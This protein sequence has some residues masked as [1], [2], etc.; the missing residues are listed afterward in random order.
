MA[1]FSKPTTLP[2]WA[3]STANIFE[4]PAAKKSLGWLFQEIPPSNFENW[5][6]N[7][8]FTWLQWVDERLSDGASADVFRIADPASFFTDLA[9]FGATAAVTGT[10]EFLDAG[11]TLV[12]TP[13]ERT[14]DL[15]L[16]KITEDTTSRFIDLGNSSITDGAGTAQISLLSQDIV[17]NANGLDLNLTGAALAQFEIN[18]P[19]ANPLFVARKDALA[20]PEFIFGGAAC[21]LT[22]DSGDVVVNVVDDEFQIVSQG[23]ATV[24]AL[25]VV[26]NSVTA[27]AVRSGSTTVAGQLNAD[28]FSAGSIMFAPVIGLSDTA[29]AGAVGGQIRRRN[30]IHACG[31]LNGGAGTIKTTVNRYNFSAVT[32]IT[33]GNY[34]VDFTLAALD[35]PIVVGNGSNLVIVRVASVGVSSALFQC[36]N[37][38]SVS[39]DTDLN[40]VAVGS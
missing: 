4:P 15:G 26:V 12:R 17:A 7:N 6:A 36:V 18:A 40:W 33:A 24:D 9:S 3:S 29:T 10:V 32:R 31:A 38:S 23:G 21:A 8:V 22:F 28:I 27:L 5:R 30:I 35:E 16:L 14:I 1:S 2:E 37:T 19:G 20:D 34:D 13:T 39:T 25:V 11:F